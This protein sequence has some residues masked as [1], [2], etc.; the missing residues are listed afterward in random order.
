MNRNRKWRILKYHICN[1]ISPDTFF[2]SLSYIFSY[3]HSDIWNLTNHH[4]WTSNDNL[5]RSANELCLYLRFLRLQQSAKHIPLWWC[6]YIWR[7]GYLKIIKSCA[8]MNNYI[9][10]YNTSHPSITYADVYTHRVYIC[11]LQHIVNSIYYVYVMDGDRMCGH[12]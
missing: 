7:D 4:R 3:Q 12:W 11:W 1:S 9:C 5:Y 8:H 6:I 2:N 10:E